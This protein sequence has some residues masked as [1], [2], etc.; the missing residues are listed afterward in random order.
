[1]PNNEPL[2]QQPMGFIAAIIVAALISGA[3]LLVTTTLIIMCHLKPTYYGAVRVQG[4]GDGLQRL[5]E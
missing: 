2:Y 4:D 5:R 3:I 1:M